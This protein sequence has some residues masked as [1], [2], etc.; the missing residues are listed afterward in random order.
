[1]GISRV[2][3]PT[4]S[5]P[6]RAVESIDGVT[7]GNVR[8]TLSRW[9]KVKELSDQV[10]LCAIHAVQSKQGYLQRQEIERVY[11]LALNLVAEI[12]NLN[13][14]QEQLPSSFS[15]EF[16]AA[17][18][19]SAVARA[20]M[21]AADVARRAPVYREYPVDHG[22][23]PEKRQNLVDNRIFMSNSNLYPHP[24]LL[25]KAPGDGATNSH[26]TEAPT[27]RK[28]PTR[29]RRG[30]LPSNKANLICLKCGTNDTP[31]WRRGPEGSNT[32][33]NA[34]GLQY[35][36]RVKREKEAKLQAEA[37]SL[38]QG[39]HATASTA[40]QPTAGSAA[41]VN[42]N[43]MGELRRQTTKGGASAAT[44]S[45]GNE[46]G[47]E[48]TSRSSQDRKAEGSIPMILNS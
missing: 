17:A 36:K 22:M 19:P 48:S 39:R 4:P 42:G 26:S 6:S 7:P 15:S 2:L 45:V 12:R 46:A 37:A 32:L 38:E 13:Y 40:A 29:R 3:S 18:A 9:Q 34:C 47:V 21:A 11:S 16:S 31:E 35:A 44:T 28:K 43:A 27:N 24:F 20:A 10:G 8:E 14:A 25:S 1:M 30:R 41:N 33:C 23:L 5:Q